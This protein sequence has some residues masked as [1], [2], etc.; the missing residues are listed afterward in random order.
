M[1]N[2]KKFNL[3]EEKSKEND[4]LIILIIFHYKIIIVLLELL[5]MYDQIKFHKFKEKRVLT[6][7][8]SELKS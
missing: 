4:K 8:L 7:F 1:K 3:N 6:R 5:K 2:L